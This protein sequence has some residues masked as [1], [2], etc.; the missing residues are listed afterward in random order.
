MKSRYS[1]ALDG[2][3]MSSIHEMLQVL[4]IHY[5]NSGIQRNTARRASGS[6]MYLSNPY[7]QSTRVTVE[8]ELHIYGTAQR[9]AA[10]QSVNKWALGKTLTTSDRPGQQL[11]VVCESYPTIE[12]AMRWT[13]PINITFT[14]YALP[15]WEEVQPVTV[16]VTN[17][18][19]YM[20]VP[21]NVEDQAAKVDAEITANAALTALSISAGENT[22][23][24]S[25]INVPA[26][27]VISIS[28]DEDGNLQ[29]THNYA[30]LLDKRTGSD[31]L[32]VKSGTGSMFSV[33]GNAT[34]VFSV[35]GLWM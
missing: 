11:H 25:G 19:E 12:S 7:M 22:I 18:E 13:D 28:H 15:Y 21:G 5:E 35:R 4:D 32:V 8:F 16:T 26:E 23:T 2:V 3:Q 17:D 31:D 9:Q 24:L 10:L 34:C 29:I 33:A 30:S 6:G 1:V 14:A 27:G 20:D